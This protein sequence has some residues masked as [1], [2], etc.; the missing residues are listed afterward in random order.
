MT[1]KE[2]EAMDAI[3]ELVREHALTIDSLENQLA[4]CTKERDGLARWRDEHMAESRKAL[5]IL[6][7]EGPEGVVDAADRVVER[8]HATIRS[9]DSLREDLREERDS[10]ADESLRGVREKY[11]AGKCQFAT[12]R[13]ME[14]LKSW[15]SILSGTFGTTDAAS[16]ARRVMRNV[17]ALEGVADTALA[18]WKIYGRFV[19]R[20][21]KDAA[22]NRHNELNDAI[23]AL[24]EALS[25]DAD[26][27]A[28][29]NRL[30]GIEVAARMAFTAY[31]WP[32]PFGPVASLRAAMGALC[33][34]LRRDDQEAPEDTGDDSEA[35]R[36]RCP[37]CK[38]I[39]DDEQCLKPHGHSGPHV[40]IEELGDPIDAE[41]VGHNEPHAF[42]ESPKPTDTESG[43]SEPTDA[44]W[45]QCKKVDDRGYR[46]VYEENH[47]DMPCKFQQIPMRLTPKGERP[48]DADDI[49]GGEDPTAIHDAF[50]AATKGE[51]Q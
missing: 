3:M 18:V 6:G 8:L 38:G 44:K 51:S 34:A 36:A 10:T 40:W 28:P 15:A 5:D 4:I 22:R 39:N 48:F 24:D 19:P 50:N 12:K 2:R 27:R 42:E 9:R 20:S 13:L 16:E 30:R 29:A 17:K 46:C 32:S 26:D 41:W 14:E 35:A 23:G 7:R 11:L 45:V 49:G 37:V 43:D 25:K 47:G 31:A 33:R 21:D 1:D